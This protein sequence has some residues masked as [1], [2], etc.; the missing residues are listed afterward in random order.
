MSPLGASSWQLLGGVRFNLGG[1]YWIVVHQRSA[2]SAEQR[3]ERA[4]T[5]LAKT[6]TQSSPTTASTSATGWPMAIALAS[7]SISV[8]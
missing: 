5:V 7:K 1:Q 3:I 4:R 2:F 6:D 8:R